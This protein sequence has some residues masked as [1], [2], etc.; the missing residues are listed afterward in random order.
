VIVEVLAETQAIA[1]VSGKERV[2]EVTY[3]S[4]AATG[5]GRLIGTICSSIP[6]KIGGVP[7][8]CLL[9]GLPLAPLGALIYLSQKVLGDRYILTNKSVEIRKSIGSNLVGRVELSSLADI[10]VSVLG[11]QEFSRAGNL[12][13]RDS[14]GSILTTLNGVV[15]PERL[16]S[17]ILEAR[18]ARVSN[19]AAFAQIQARK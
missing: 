10:T 17:A 16:K 2:I 6:L 9:F 12:Q 19:D 4:I 15:W 18:Q 5:L 7:L 8:S 11:G 1:G 3:P 14:K 13:L